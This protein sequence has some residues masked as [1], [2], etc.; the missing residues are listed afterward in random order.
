MKKKKMKAT[1]K[2]QKMEKG[3]AGYGAASGEMKPIK[4]TKKGKK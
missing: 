3:M 4:K 1:G 2:E